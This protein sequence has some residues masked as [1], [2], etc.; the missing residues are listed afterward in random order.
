MTATKNEFNNSAKIY[1]GIWERTDSGV[2]AIFGDPQC[3]LQKRRTEAKRIL[4]FYQIARKFKLACEEPGKRFAPVF[5]AVDAEQEVNNCSEAIVAVERV[6]GKLTKAY[7]EDLLV[8]ATKVL[9]CKFKSPIVI[10]DR[11]TIY[12]F[13]FQRKGLRYKDFFDK[14]QEEFQKR[15]DEISNACDGLNPKTSE[16]KKNISQRWFRERVFDRYLML[17]GM[18]KKRLP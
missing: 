2:H 3:E 4:A 5:K 16:G 11:L 17:L 14:W 12:P 8:P 9:W 7:G 18:S 6:R 10:C 1:L 15:Q 13:G